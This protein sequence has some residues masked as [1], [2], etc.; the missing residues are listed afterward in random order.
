MAEEPRHHSVEFP[1]LIER[2]VSIVESAE[3]HQTGS[4]GSSY[5]KVLQHIYFLKLVKRGRDGEG[6]RL[7]LHPNHDV[8]ARL[9]R[10]I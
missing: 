2:V 10:C 4:L 5:R 8:I 3:P 9:T 1:L 7:E 6:R